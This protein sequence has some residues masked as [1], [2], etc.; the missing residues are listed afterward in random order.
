[1]TQAEYQAYMDGLAGKVSEVLDGID[2]E[3]ATM[4]LAAMLGWGLRHLYQSRQDRE[5]ALAA[6]VELLVREAFKG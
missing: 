2:G 4:V 5:T 6:L 1:M 3:D